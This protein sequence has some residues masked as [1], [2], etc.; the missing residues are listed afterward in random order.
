VPGHDAV[1]DAGE[2]IGNGIGVHVD[3]SL[4]AGLLDARQLAREGVLPE[5]KAAEL[6]LPDV[7]AGAAADLAPV[8]VP[9][10][11]LGLL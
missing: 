5:A 9:D 10:G 6:E 1:A 3:S 8:A 4:P 11:K 2:E 7:A